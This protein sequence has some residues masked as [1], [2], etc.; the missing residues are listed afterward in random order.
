MATG[1]SSP[2][3]AKK[4]QKFVATSR[5]RRKVAAA[6]KRSRT[7]RKAVHRPARA[8]KLRAGTARRS[9]AAAEKPSSSVLGISPRYRKAL[10]EYEKAIAYLQ[11]RNFRRAAQLFERFIEDYSEERDLADR[12]RVYLN[13]CRKQTEASFELQGF[14]DHY[15]HGVFLVNRG[16]FREA[17]H[18]FQK[19]LELRPAS[20][21]ANFSLAS[22]YARID[23]KPSALEFLRKAVDL[24]GGNRLLGRQDPDFRS[25]KGDPEFEQLLGRDE[26]TPAE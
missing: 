1:R 15:Y 19:A 22:A 2:A 13:L 8:R 23:E 16:E 10:A 3:K 12:G 7:A 26:G 17:I 24:D 4:K 6:P 18:V 11:K 9:R 25:L 21:K 14:D 20:G 5:K